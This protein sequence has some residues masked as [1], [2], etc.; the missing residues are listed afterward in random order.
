MP[1]IVISMQYANQGYSAN[2]IWTKFE[3]T[4]T[5]SMDELIPLKKLN[6]KHHLPWVAPKVKKMI[7]K[8]IK[9]HTKYEQ[10]TKPSAS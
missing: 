5:S 4:L 7:H 9:I 2:D 3:S 6:G 1:S 8:R 10:L